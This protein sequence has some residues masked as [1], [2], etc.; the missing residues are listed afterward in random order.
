[1]AN[2]NKGLGLDLTKYGQNVNTLDTEGILRSLGKRRPQ[3][4]AMGPV[5]L[6]ENFT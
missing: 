5:P 1:V 4:N 6:S 2:T 3:I